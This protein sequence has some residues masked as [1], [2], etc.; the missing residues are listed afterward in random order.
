MRLHTPEK[1]E[2]SYEKLRWSTRKRLEFI[3]NRLFWEEKISRKDLT[4]FFE[5]SIPQATK[6]FKQYSE[7]APDNLFYDTSAKQYVATQTFKPKLTIPDSSTYFSRL[8]V[9]DFNDAGDAFFCGSVP[10]YYKLPIPDR[11]V[12]PE[13]LKRLLR[14]INN[15][16]QIEIYYQSMNSSD[17][18]WRVISPHSFG[19]NGFRW[20]V[21]ALCHK[22]LE[23]RDFIFGRILS[24]G[25]DQKI[26]FDHSND[27]EW[28]SDVRFRI[29]PN[30]D[31]SEG[32]KKS[33]EY[34]YGMEGGETFFDVKTA[35][36]FYVERRLGLTREG[37]NREGYQQ[38]I[39]ILNREEVEKK[40]YVLKEMSIMKIK[41]FFVK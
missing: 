1:Q 29:G 12:E 4:D 34:D 36:V 2:F 19:Y 5:I 16:L 15:N 41:E 6:D 28:H 18:A 37:E 24:L 10:S 32:Q 39:V 25:E 27:F 8:L 21:R 23:Y 9:G 35:F 22:N 13:V 17:P 38:H 33:I 11:K 40:I 14:C 26:N 31:Q 7:I 20:H 30:P 3:E